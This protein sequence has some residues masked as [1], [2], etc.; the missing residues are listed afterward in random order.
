MVAGTERYSGPC[1]GQ[2]LA[3]AAKLKVQVEGDRNESLG[4]KARIGARL[5]SLRSI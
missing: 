5:R 1:P 2:G 3:F 4:Q